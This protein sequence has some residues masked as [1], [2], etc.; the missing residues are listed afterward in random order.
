MILSFF[1]FI[2]GVVKTIFIDILYSVITE[3]VKIYFEC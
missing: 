3:P 1:N 2:F